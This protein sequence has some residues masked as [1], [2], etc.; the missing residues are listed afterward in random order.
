MNL[1]TFFL[2]LDAFN[3]SI[4]SRVSSEG[5]AAGLPETVTAMVFERLI[6]VNNNLS[7]AYR[8]TAFETSPVGIPVEK[9]LTT[10]SYDDCENALILPIIFWEIDLLALPFEFCRVF[11]IS[12]SILRLWF[13][14]F[15]LVTSRSK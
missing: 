7:V 13:R 8:L 15:F 6:I 12:F 3:S 2:S 9:V 11:D 1:G 14:R 4:L 5:M 10:G